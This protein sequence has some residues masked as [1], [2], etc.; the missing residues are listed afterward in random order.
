MGALPGLW[1]TWTA[2]LDLRSQMHAVPS[3][4]AD[5]MVSPSTDKDKALMAR[6]W[7]SILTNEELMLAP[8]MPTCIDKLLL[9]PAP[10]DDAWL[11]KPLRALELFVEDEEGMRGT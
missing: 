10:D 8:S 5:T 3:S 2:C 11:L 1:I 9:G 4:D 7:P 6:E